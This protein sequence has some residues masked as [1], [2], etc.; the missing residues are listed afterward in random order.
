MTA[1]MEDAVDG[2]AD[3]FG[4]PGGMELAGLAHGVGQTDVDLPL[5]MVR[6]GIFLM[7]EGDDVSG[8]FVIQIFPVNPG[9]LRGVDEMK[10]QFV[11]RDGRGFGEEAGEDAPQEAGFHRADGLAVAN[12]ERRVH[13]VIPSG[14]PRTP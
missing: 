14:A 8:T 3:E 9:H 6:F 10:T 4:L 1:E 13:R 5:E 12:G 2:V 11:G 7:I